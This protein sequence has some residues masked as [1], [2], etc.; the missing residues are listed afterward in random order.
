MA[1]TI[2][3]DGRYHIPIVELGNRLQDRFGLTVVEHPA[4]GGVTVKHADNS[5]HYFDE[6]I[7]IQDHRGG[8]GDG[9]EGFN[10]MGYVQRTKNLANLLHGSGHEILGPGTP[11]H[12]THL[13]IGNHGG[14]FKL[15]QQQY[16]Y[17]FGGNSGGLSSTFDFSRDLSTPSSVADTTVHPVN[18]ADMSASQINAEYDKLRMAGDVFKAEDEG[19]KMH[20]AHFKK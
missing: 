19:M 9:A 14:I 11:G 18:Y 1:H 15:D 17:L 4:F 6:A 3:D 7:D 13:H 5:H 20:K 2:N 16:D 10:G 8:A 12:D